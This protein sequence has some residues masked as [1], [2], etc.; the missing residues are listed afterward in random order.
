MIAIAQPDHITAWVNS[1]YLVVYHK[2]SDKSFVKFKCSRMPWK[3]TLLSPHTPMGSSKLNQDSEMCATFSWIVD[4]AKKEPSFEKGTSNPTVFMEVWA[5][6]CFK[7]EHSYTLTFAGQS[8]RTMTCERCSFL[9]RRMNHRIEKVN[10]N[11]QQVKSQHVSTE[12][13]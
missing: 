10:E 11:K 12:E 5:A 4:C 6:T 8:R 9:L 7:S 13:S 3:V 2:Q 1:T